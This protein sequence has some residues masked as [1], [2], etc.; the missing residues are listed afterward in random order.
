MIDATEQRGF[1]SITWKLSVIVLYRLFSSDKEL[2][3]NIFRWM[4]ESLSLNNR[5]QRTTH[6]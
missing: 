3:Q 6:N 4:C 2:N 5:Y 1:S